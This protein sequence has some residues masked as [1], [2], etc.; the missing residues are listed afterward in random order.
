MNKFIAISAILVLLALVALAAWRHSR[1]LRYERIFQN[2]VGA[3][4]MCFGSLIVRPDV[5]EQRPIL[6]YPRSVK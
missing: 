3:W 4:T 2:L 6:P 1:H 5:R